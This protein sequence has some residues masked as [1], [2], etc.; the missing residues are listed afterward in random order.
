MK[1]VG[2]VT[3]YN[4]FHYGHK[5]HLENSIAQTGA[6]HSTMVAKSRSTESGK[7]EKGNFS[8]IEQ[9]RGFVFLMEITIFKSSPRTKSKAWHNK[10]IRLFYRQTIMNDVL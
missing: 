4:P 5:Y 10:D 1:V 2:F 6:T 9:V 7:T 8:R 3:E